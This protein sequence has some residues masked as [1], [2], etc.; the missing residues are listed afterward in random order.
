MLSFK[1]SPLWLRSKIFM[2]IPLYYSFLTHVTRMRNV[3]NERC[4]YAQHMYSVEMRKYQYFLFGKKNDGQLS[5][6]GEKMCTILV[7]RL[8]D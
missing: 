6:S 2:L 7:N 1:S 5:V 3:R 8:E 4:A